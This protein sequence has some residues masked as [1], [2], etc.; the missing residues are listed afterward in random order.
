MMKNA[1]FELPTKVTVVKVT[2]KN[3][4]HNHYSGQKLLFCPLEKTFRSIRNGH[5]RTKKVA[6][7][8]Y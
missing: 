2:Y 8:E 7:W 1:D 4:P 3:D 6:F 5:N